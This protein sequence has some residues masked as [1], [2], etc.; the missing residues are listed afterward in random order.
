MFWNGWPLERILI[1]FVALAFLMIGIQVGLFHYRGNFRHRIMWSPVIDAP[2]LGLL[3]LVLAF[4]NVVWL[5]I[6]YS[7]LLG[8]TLLV[9]LAGAV[10]HVRG[11]MLRV[12]GW[13]FRN[14]LTGPPL[15]LPLMLSAI[16]ALG[17]IVLYWG[18]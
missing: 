15:M 2:V 10:I 5:K 1:L 13:E 8:I 9:A 17:L 18:R 11:V 6:V 14:V 12:G 3:G 7:W 4:Y 16:S